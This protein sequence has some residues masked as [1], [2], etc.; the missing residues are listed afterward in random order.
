[1]F[2]YIV[3]DDEITLFWS[4]RKSKL[5]NILLNGRNI[6][7][8]TKTHYTIAGLKENHE[9]NIEITEKIDE[10]IFVT[11]KVIKVKT[12]IKRQ[13]IDITK[14]PY[15]AIG[16]GK[17][18]NTKAI[19]K[20]INDCGKNQRVYF[21]A[22]EFLCGSIKLKSNSELY[23]A[24]GAILKASEKREDY[25]PKV[26]TRFEGKKQLSYRAFID[27]GDT[28]SSCKI[29][30]SNIVIRGGGRIVG[31]G[32]T[33][34]KDI[35][36]YEYEQMIRD[37]DTPVK[38]EAEIKVLK[39]EA[40]RTRPRLI[41]IANTNN[42]VISNIGIENGPC[43]NLHIVYSKNCVTYGCKF[44]SHD[45]S[46]G[47]GWDPDS[48]KNCYLF[49]CI[50]DTG[51]DCIAIKSGKNPEGN[52]VNIPCENIYIFDCRSVWGHSCSIGSEMSG[53]VKNVHIYDCDFSK[54]FFGITIKATA[55][56]G[57]YVRN[58]KVE[59]CSMPR[60][61]VRI[62]NYND[63]GA[64]ANYLPIFKNFYCKDLELTGI[65][66]LANGNIAKC[67]V[68]SLTGFDSN[69]YALNNVV[70]DGITIPADD[71]FKH[72]DISNLKNLTIKNINFKSM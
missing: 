50:F 18:K 61:M 72:I 53:G 24:D 9:Y 28:D 22:G 44:V 35:I 4:K 54:T 64:P 16:D 57:G 29:N 30:A 19:Q 7:S 67:E 33:L 62:A 38:D 42:C 60:F 31:G 13:N 69:E 56:R 59:N 14:Y 2:K 70:L 25:L 55:K 36:E 10:N 34:R 41:S 63:D 58:V 23:L 45:V 71:S 15:N 8:T 32:A 27:V 5:Y 40:G 49:D 46:N 68:I 1:M 17:T 48:S 11:Y 12:K 21:P 26:I 43:W 3:F 47:D 37:M 20:A 66:Y 6:G 51:D 52:I 65:A 39:N